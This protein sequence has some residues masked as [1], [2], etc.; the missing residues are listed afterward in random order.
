MSSASPRHIPVML[1]E[2]LSTAAV[3]EGD[4]VVDGTFGNGGYSRA[5]LEA[6]AQ[7]IGIDRDPSAAQIAADLDAEWPNQF[8][9]IQ[10]QFSQM[11]LYLQDK[12]AGLADVVV[13]DVGVSSMQIDQADRGFSFQK[14]GPLDMRMSSSGVS[15]ADIVNH[16]PIKALSDILFQL[17][18]ERRAPAIARAIDMFRQEKPFTRTLELAGLIE[19]VVGRKPRDPIHPATRSFQAL[20]IFVNGE[21][22]E[23]ARGLGAAERVL[24]PGGRLIVVTFHSLEDRIVKRFLTDRSR[25]RGGGSRYAPE[26]QL[27]PPTFTLISRRAMAA[28]AE[29]IDQ[30]PR[31]RSAKLRAGIRTEA[32]PRNIDPLQLSVPKVGT[33]YPEGDA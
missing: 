22:L 9:L 11:D 19:Q 16:Y 15:A 33:R 29:E 18:E 26:A 14:D 21:L 28:S 20:R 31:S 7:V 23:L 3:N 13:L 12:Q 1:N 6:G 25:T 2:V 10:G 32:A 4:L 24:K 17:G 5:F 8:D 27:A 30:N